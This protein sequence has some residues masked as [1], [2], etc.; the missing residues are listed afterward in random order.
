MIG[1]VCTSFIAQNLVHLSAIMQLGMLTMMSE[2]AYDILNARY[3]RRKVSDATFR[4]H[5]I[6]TWVG[7]FCLVVCGEPLSRRI[8]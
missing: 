6:R 3:R 1:G 4:V 7:V 2:I 8:S 5:P